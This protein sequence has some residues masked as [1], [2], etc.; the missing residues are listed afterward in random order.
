[1]AATLTPTLT[2]TGTAADFGAAIAVSVTDSIALANGKATVHKIVSPDDIAETGA[3]NPQIFDA[4]NM[5]RSFIY[6]KNLNAADGKEIFLVLTVD[7]AVD[8]DI[9]MHLEPGE[10]AFFPWAG[11]LDLFAH[12]GADGA[13]QAIA[14]LEYM[15]WEV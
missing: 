2:I 12:T 10:F 4:G 15:I 8:S 3:V 5:G 9:Y 14:G 1:M 13:G 6:A 7:E 11:I